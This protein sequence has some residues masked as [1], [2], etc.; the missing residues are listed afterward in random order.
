MV[1]FCLTDQLPTSTDLIGRLLVISDRF[2]INTLRLQCE[3]ALAKLLVTEKCAKNALKLFSFSLQTT[4]QFLAMK[5]ARI[6]SKD[7]TVLLETGNLDQISGEDLEIL[8]SY[9]HQILDD[10]FIRYRDDVPEIDFCDDLIRSEIFQNFSKILP[11]RRR[12]RSSR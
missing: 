9:Y 5:C 2:M 7:L 1:D 12:R 3:N 11:R 8:S 10:D 6:L 4:A